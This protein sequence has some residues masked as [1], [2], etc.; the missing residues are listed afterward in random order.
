MVKIGYLLTD[1][2]INLCSH[3]TQILRIP[4][5]GGLTAAEQ[6]IPQNVIRISKNFPGPAGGHQA[7]GY[8]ILEISR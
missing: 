1:P 8:M 3:G 5:V 6:F 7:E 4:A 2:L